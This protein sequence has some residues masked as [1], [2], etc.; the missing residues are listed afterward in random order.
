M[1]VRVSDLASG[2]FHS[3]KVRNLKYLFLLL[4]VLVALP[5]ATF[6]QSAT[7]VGTVTDQSGGV[8]A[9]V[10]ITITSAETGAVKTITTNDSGQYVVPDLAIG[11]YSIKAT[12]NGFKAVEQKDVVATVGDRLRIDFQMA[13]GAASETVTVE[14]NPIA[15][16]ADSG[17]V[18]NLITDKQVS[19]LAVNG[20]SIYQLAQLTPGASSQINGFVNTPVGGDSNVEFN[21]LRQNHN[22]YLL[23]GGENDDRGGAGGM[24]IAPSTDAIAEFRA[25]TSNYSADFGLSSAATM[26]MVLK[27]GTST[28]HASAWEFNR[29]D[30]FDA[31]GFFNP[32][33]NLNGSPN[34]VAKLR[35][36]VFG[37][38][39][40]GPV[41]L[42]KLYNADRKKTFFFY[43]MEWRRLIQGSTNA[44]QPVPDPATYGGDFSS[45]ATTIFVPSASQVASSVLFANCPG[46][47]APLGVVQGSAFPQNKIP[48]CMISTNAEALA[49]AGIFPKPTSVGDKF[50]GAVSTPTNL[51][52]E[53]VRIDHNFNSKFS[54][55]GH[56]IAEQVSQGYAISQWSGANIPTV[57]D[58]FGNP[59]YS[60]VVHTTY[61]ISPS[62]LNEVAFN[63][64]GNRINIIPNAGAGLGSLALPTGY[65]STNSRLFTGPNNLSRIPNIDL[66]GATGAK[67]EISSWPWRNKA[68]DY[69]IRDD[70]SWTKGKHQLKMGGSWALYKKVQDLFGQTQGGFTFDGSFTGSDF[71]D[72]LLG[73][74]K[75]YQELAV[76]DKGLWNNVSWAAYIQDNWRATR[77]LTLNLGLRWDGVPH[78]YEAND[79]MGN[80]YQ[81]LYDPTLTATFNSNGTI[82][83]PTDTA[84][85]GCPG[86]ASPGLGTS[87]NS[88]LAGV[89]LYLN[90]IGIPGKN[91]VPKGLVDNHWA[92][93]GP[94]IGFAY[95]LTGSGK[96]VVRGGFG[97]MYERIQGN[98][99]YNAGPNIPFSLQVSTPV[100][101]EMNNPSIALSNGV[102]H[103]AANLPINPADITGLNRSQYK[104]PASYQWSL[105][106]QRAL[107]SKTVLSVAYVGNTN[108]YQNY[109]TEYN[110][111]DQAD[112]ANIINGANYSTAP[113][114]P[115]SGFHSVRLSTNEANSHYNGLQ[116]DVNSQVGRDLYL[117]AFYTYSKSIDPGTGSNGGQ[118]LQNASNPYLGWKYDSGP[119]GYDRTHNAVVNFIYDI[120]VF[121]NS[122]SHLLKTTLGGWQVSGIVTLE[123]GIPI[124]IGM[125]NQKDP[126]T[127]LVLASSNNGIPNATNR[128]NLVGTINYPQ[129][130]LTCATCQQAIQYLDPS[131]FG[132][133][134]VGTFGNLGHNAIRGPGRDNWNLSLFKSFVF[135][136]SRGSRLEIG[137]ETFNVWNHTQ[138]N[139]VS[140]NFGSSNFGQFTSAFDPRT[141][142][143]RGKIY[144]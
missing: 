20:R 93:F 64:N 138:F 131:A 24:S 109:Y 14:A 62:L 133:P 59:S 38:N 73:D 78:T 98:D 136:E 97:I 48:S 81:S 69:Q 49:T 103:T 89:P 8:V 35:L 100:P 5:A 21:G 58:T 61:A 143:L 63:Y 83:G 12:A 115:F 2:L 104:Q 45:S 60:A 130:V 51:K 85:T 9:G 107:S 65:D 122:S 67:F 140:N 25:L 82:C 50:T 72:F 55:F 17:E 117:R 102:A 79:R 123:S 101:V 121:R 88:I 124:N 4:L 22:I 108:R 137:L 110:L 91:G 144:F 77:R 56:F 27:S 30:G 10:T 6:G 28:L 134:T 68:D 18:S 95:D 46:G 90:G 47:I 80:F 125:A 74:A 118:D 135:S 119:G 142:Q 141:V 43:N 112:L 96:T 31:R 70:V 39:V 26:T 23:D 54:V 40:G 7:L 53:V 29:N 127:K 15:V 19:Q 52:E 113:G 116:L 84:A 37:F 16:Q 114:I 71:A 3:S 41:T 132:L 126:V 36:N 129:T 86:G 13:L 111:P 76:Q 94:R 44:S 106:V 33:Q 139:Q 87:P 1:Q 32:G 120:P 99:M 128:P 11:H 57:G 34:P 42:G 92:N 75:Q 105:G 66:T